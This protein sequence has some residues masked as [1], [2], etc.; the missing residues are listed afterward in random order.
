MSNATVAQLREYL[1]QVGSGVA[2]D[3]LLQKVLDRACEVVGDYLGM[4]FGAYTEGVKDVRAPRNVDQWLE[5]PAHE[6]DSVTAVARVSGRG[7]LGETTS[8]VSDFLEE[9]DGR[10]YRDG[11]WTPGA[12]YRVTAD[13]GYGVAP[14]SVVEVELRVAVNIWQ[15]R[16]A[17]Q[18]QAN[19]GV[20]GSGS[21]TYS[22]ALTG[23]ERSILD[24]VR[25][26]FGVWGFA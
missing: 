7:T 21:V 24:G 17:S 25:A 6:A 5:L 1:E 11:G 19:L 13:W 2:V 26:R 8:A 20:E 16:A 4:A 9:D 10:L 18:W 23:A 14:A 12:W 3:A 15:G 22:R